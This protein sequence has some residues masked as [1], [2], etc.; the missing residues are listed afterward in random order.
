MEQGPAKKLYPL[1]WE[2]QDRL[3]RELP[4][5]LQRMVLYK[6]NTGCREQEVCQLRW[7]WEVK[8]PEP[9]KGVFVLPSNN[10][11]ETKNS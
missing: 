5:Y 9:K 1:S 3:F 2:E 6:V 8:I 11:F 4:A 10:L 7:D